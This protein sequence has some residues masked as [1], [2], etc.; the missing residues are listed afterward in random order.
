MNLK[1][2]MSA[3]SIFR[4][5]VL[6]CLFAMHGAAFSQNAPP[7]YDGF[8]TYIEEKC[9]GMVREALSSP[10][11]APIFFNHAVDLKKACTCTK[12][13]FQEDKRLREYLNVDTATQ[14]T[15]I[16]TKN[17]QTY[18]GVRLYQSLMA[19]IDPELNDALSAAPLD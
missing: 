14:A 7:T 4:N 19:C 11:L 1:A 2:S 3:A 10:Q 15:R 9:P 12:N 13:K 8:L 5:R 18:G 17:F 6:A 16:R